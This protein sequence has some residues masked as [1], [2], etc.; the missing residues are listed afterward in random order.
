MESNHP[1]LHS[2]SLIA[3]PSEI[4]PSIVFGELQYAYHVAAN[5]E[6]ALILGR[7]SLISHTFYGP[8]K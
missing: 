3:R 8:G 5:R 7:Y 1:P 4:C 2:V 6:H